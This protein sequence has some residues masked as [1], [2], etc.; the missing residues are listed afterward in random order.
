[1]EQLARVT[2]DPPQTDLI[3]RIGRG[4]REA[5]HD[6]FV[7]HNRRVYSIALNFF[8]G[9]ADKACDVTQQVFLKLFTNG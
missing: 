6:M 5:M 4:S 2:K 7:A 8:S 3:D 1:M 9:D